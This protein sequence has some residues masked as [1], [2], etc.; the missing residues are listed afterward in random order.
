MHGV[1]FKF[2]SYYLFPDLFSLFFSCK[3][4]ELMTDLTDA[5]EEVARWREACELEVEAGKAAMEERDKEVIIPRKQELGFLKIMS[6]NCYFHASSTNSF[7][8]LY[9]T[10]KV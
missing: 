4:E 9:S 5:E 10:N 7:I 6:P 2:Q 8:V 3:V 1:F